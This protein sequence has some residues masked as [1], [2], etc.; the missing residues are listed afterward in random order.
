MPEI[1]HFLNIRKQLIFYTL[2]LKVLAHS[3]FVWI[4]NGYNIK[5]A[6]TRIFIELGIAVDAF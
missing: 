1:P 3:L 4:G 6:G 2:A 5:F